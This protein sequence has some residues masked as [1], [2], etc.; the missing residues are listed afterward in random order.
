MEKRRAKLRRNARLLFFITACM[1]FKSMNAFMTLF[2]LRRGVGMSALF[3]LAIVFSVTTLISEVPSGYLADRIG[4]K[5]TLLFGA[6]FGV[7]SQAVLF[8]AYGVRL[9]VVSLVMYSLACSCFSGTQEALLYDGLQ[10]TNESHRMTEKNGRMLAGRQISKIILPVLGSLIARDLRE[11]QFK[12]L[13][14]LDMLG[15]A[16]AF[17]LIL[18]LLEPKRESRT[19]R[20]SVAYRGIFRESLATIRDQPFLLRAGMN[21]KLVFITAFIFWRS[22]QPFLESHGR[23]GVWLSVTYFFANIVMVGFFWTASTW[24][25]RF[26]TASILQWTSGIGLIG[27]LA[28]LAT[29]RPWLVFL[30]VTMT[31]TV[32][33]LRDPVF[34]HVLNTRIDSQSRATTLSNLNMLKAVLDIPILLLTAFVTSYDLRYAFAVCAALHLLA[35]VAFPVRARDLRMSSLP[36]SVPS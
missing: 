34:A 35:L 24:E 14:G 12:L 10:E 21:N 13:I 5:R 20:P 31:F 23:G 17:V 7:A 8:N 29:D 16:I 26:G 19:V 3:I 22:Y 9:Y 33:P 25:K 4:R 27:C 6:A 11:W 32:V 15:M 36:E 30:I 1:E 28:L 2:Y 18:F